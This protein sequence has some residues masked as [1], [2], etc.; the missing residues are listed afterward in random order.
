MKYLKYLQVFLLFFVL[1][2]F[3]ISC[4]TVK[5]T[6]Q[7]YQS[8]VDTNISRISYS[9][10]LHQELNKQIL[11]IELDS[12]KVITIPEQNEKPTMTATI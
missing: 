1:T 8:V 11:S 9:D 10:S 5:D 7:G 3:V 2:L 4:Q 6:S 12:L